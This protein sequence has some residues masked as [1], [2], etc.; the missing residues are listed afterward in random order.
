MI[1]VAS[2]KLPGALAEGGLLWIATVIGVDQL[3]RNSRS[4]L[5]ISLGL[6]TAVPIAANRKIARTLHEEEIFSPTLFARFLERMDP[7]GS[8]RTLGESAYH[9]P[10][11]LIYRYADSSDGY[12]AAQR[13]TWIEHL[14]A[15]W[16]RG[17]V[18]NHDFDS[19]DFAR[20]QSLRRLSTSAAG[21]SDSRPFFGSVALRWGIRFRDQTPLS[22][23]RRI[24]GDWLQ[25][26]DE[27][28]E[29]LPEIRLATHW[30]E[31]ESPL[32]S[33]AA[34]PRLKPGE[35]VLETGR[36]ARGASRGGIVRVRR[37]APERLIVET[38]TS[39]P[40]WLFVLR[41]FWD[42][43]AVLVDGKAVEDVPAQL[44]FSAVA[45]PPG[46]HTIDWRERVPG[47]VVSRWGPVLYALAALILASRSRR[48]EPGRVQ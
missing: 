47:G 19:G 6:L 29:A 41:G 18:F 23:Y 12:T 8:Y 22:G 16:G 17:I 42:H 3:R 27:L 48:R 11:P 15:L 43:R 33:L 31:E 36:R 44:A 40:S 5:A 13:R 1:P 20:L 35:I 24:G 28:E 10:S 37:N 39:D 34:L 2:K 46:R 7:G 4:A 14:P 45:I 9:P 21:Y 25:D 26:W 38:L 30:V 32:A